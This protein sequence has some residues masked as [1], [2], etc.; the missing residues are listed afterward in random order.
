VGLIFEPF[1]QG[2]RALN[3]PTDGVGLG[4]AISR[5]L[6][7]GMGGALTVESEVGRGS[8]FSLTLARAGVAAPPT[9]PL[10][11]RPSAA[12]AA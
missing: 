12:S 1:V 10:G 11:G 5:E 4:L 3:R 8:T 7:L 9:P 2:V 6:A